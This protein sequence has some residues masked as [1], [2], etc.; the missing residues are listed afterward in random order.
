MQSFISFS[1]SL[2]FIAMNQFY[3]IY[4]VICFIHHFR[5]KMTDRRSLNSIEIDVIVDA[6]P[7]SFFHQ[8][9]NISPQCDAMDCWLRNL[10]VRQSRKSRNY[11]SILV[12]HNRRNLSSLLQQLVCLGCFSV[13]VCV[14]DKVYAN[15][16]I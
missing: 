14:S 9:P 16:S 2:F 11:L 7:P 15:V 5:Y 12:R 8:L 13:Y 1:L 10:G 4:C 6:F 3:S